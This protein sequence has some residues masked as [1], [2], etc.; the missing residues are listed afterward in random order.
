MNVHKAHPLNACLPLMPNTHTHAHCSHDQGTPR[1]SRRCFGT[2]GSR[3]H[4]FAAP[5]REERKDKEEEVDKV[6]VETDSTKDVVVVLHSLADAVCVVEN[7]Q[8]KDDTTS[9]CIN[10]AEGK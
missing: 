2:P 5:T 4:L 3:S 1:E 7:V 6:E 10:L 9:E 8:H